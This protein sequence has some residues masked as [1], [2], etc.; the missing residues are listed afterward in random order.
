LWMGPHASVSDRFEKVGHTVEIT[1]LRNQ[2][3]YI[4]DW[5]EHMR[6]L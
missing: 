4:D 3:W 5:T 1:D 2:P 6:R